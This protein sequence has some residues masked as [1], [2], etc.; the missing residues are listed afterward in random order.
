MGKPNGKLWIV[1][2]ENGEH[3]LLEREP[4][5]GVARWAKGQNVTVLE[6]SFAKVVY[7]EEPR[8]AR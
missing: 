4:L 3:Y 5:E 8:A 7:P 2:R 1:V 6:Y